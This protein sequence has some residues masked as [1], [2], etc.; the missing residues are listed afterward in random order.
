MSDCQQQC[1]LEER[2]K[3]LEEKALKNSGEHKEFYNK[4]EKIGLNNQEHD[5]ALKNF[6]EKLDR[7]ASDV[8]ALKE[9]PISRG[10]KFTSA[11]ITAIGSSIGT[12][13]LLLIVYSIFQ[14]IP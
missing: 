3:Q 5:I 2:I 14:T 6:D 4:F 7:I 12:G 1:R 8:K 13:I 11:I 9:K 10:E